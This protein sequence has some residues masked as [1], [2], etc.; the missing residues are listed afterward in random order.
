MDGAK[1]PLRIAQPRREVGH[2]LEPDA[3]ELARPPLP[4]CQRVKPRHRLRQFA[5]RFMLVDEID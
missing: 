3:H 4:I 5:V 1:R 2:R